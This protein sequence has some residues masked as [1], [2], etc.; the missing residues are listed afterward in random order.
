MDGLTRVLLRPPA[1]LGAGESSIWNSAATGGDPRRRGGTARRAAADFA[2]V[3]V[4]DLVALAADLAT[5]RVPAST[6][7]G[8]GPVAGACTPVNVASGAATVRDYYE[9]VTGASA[10]P[11]SGT[12][13]RRGP[14]G[15][16]PT[17]PRSWGWT[18]AV[19]L[20]AAFDEVAEGLA[21]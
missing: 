12:T 7:P 18:P 9:A 15:S 16:W 19:D 4:D 17:A 8:T 10:S 14:A 1:I 21:P 6:D 3:H 11:R 13:G 20:T 5:G 2:W